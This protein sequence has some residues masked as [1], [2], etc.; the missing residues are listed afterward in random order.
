MSD[1]WWARKLGGAPEQRRA[2]TPARG[3]QQW[4]PTPQYQPPPAQEPWARSGIDPVQRPA[5]EISDD[6]LAFMEDESGTYT[7]GKAGNVTEMRSDGS[8]GSVAAA[9]MFLRE[10]PDDVDPSMLSLADKHEFFWQRTARA[11]LRGHSKSL[12]AEPE[13]CPS[14]GDPRYFTRKANSRNGKMPA[15]MCMACSYTGDS[16]EISSLNV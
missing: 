7:Y 13:R 11:P 15:P 12:R 14:C 3:D 10:I 8:R 5:M 4:Y 16:Y 9:P 6:V 1:G 2:S